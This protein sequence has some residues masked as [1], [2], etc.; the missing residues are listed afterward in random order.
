ML[1]ELDGVEFNKIWSNQLLYLKLRSIVFDYDHGLNLRTYLV[2][3]KLINPTKI[4]VILPWYQ[5]SYINAC[6]IVS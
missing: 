6:I 3:N 2:A 1:G 5:L 4:S